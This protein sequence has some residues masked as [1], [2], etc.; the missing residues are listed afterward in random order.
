[1]N[2]IRSVGMLGVFALVAGGALANVKPAGRTD[3]PNSLTVD[4]AQQRLNRDSGYFI[5]N[6]GQWDSQALFLA[7]TPSLA[8]WLTRDGVTYDYLGNSS[9]RS[10]VAG[11]VVKMSFAG[12]KSGFVLEAEGKQSK[13]I[14]Y[15]T[16]GGERVARTT[17]FAEVWGR[18]IYAGV[19]MRSYLDNGRPRYDFVVAPGADPGQ[20]RLRFEGADSVRIE[21]GEIKLGTALGDLSHGGLF[22]YQDFG[23]EKRPVAASFRQVDATTIGFEVGAYDRTRALV[24]DPLV[25]GS[26][27]GGEGGW[28]EVRHV[29]ADPQGGVYL[30]GMTRSAAFPAV[31]GPYGFNR[32]GPM[33]AFVSKLQGD[34]YSHDYAA[35]VGGSGS[36]FGQFIRLDPFGDVWIAGRTNSANFPGNTKNTSGNTDIFVMRFRQSATNVLNPLPSTTFMFGGAGT[37]L[38]AGFDI[39]PNPNPSLNSP[40]EFV[41]AGNFVGGGIPEV[42]GSAAGQSGFIA[43]VRFQN[44]TFSVVNTATQY[45]SGGDGLQIGGVVVDHEGN[46]LLAGHV[47][48]QGNVDT[49]INPVFVTTPGVFENGR[50][51]RNNDVFIRKYSPAG[52]MIYSALIGGNGFDVIGGLAWDEA[53]AFVNA[54]SAVAVDATGN[55]YI[56]GLAGSFNFPR[57]RGVYGEVFTAFANVFVTKVSADGSQIIYSTNLRTSDRVLPS[58]IAVDQRGY[59]FVTGMVYPAGLVFP[60]TFTGMPSTAGNPNEPTSVQTWGGIQITPDALDPDWTRLEPPQ[61][62]TNEGFINV[63]NETATELVY[64]SYVGAI[65]NE[66]VFGP[67]VDRFG[68]VWI[69]GSIDSYRRYVLFNNQGDQIERAHPS[70]GRISLPDSLVSPLAFKRFNDAGMPTV[71]PGVLWG[72]LSPSAPN[73]I[74]WNFTP[75]DTNP[76]SALPTI[77]VQIARDGFL[78]KKRVGLPAVANIALIPPTV[79]GGLGASTVATFTLTS[80]APPEGADV[81]VTIGDPGIASFAPNEAQGMRLVTIPPGELTGSVTIYTRPVAQTTGVEVRATY[82]GSFKIAQLNVVPWLQQLTLIPTQIVGGNDATGRVTLAAPAPAGGITVDLITDSPSLISFRG[83]GGGAITQVT[84]PQGQ[85]SVTFTIRTEG[86]DTTRHPTITASLLGVGRTQTLTLERASLASITLTP[87]RVAG[88]TIVKGR[89]NLNGRAASAVTVNLSVPAGAPVTVPAQVVIPAGA[90]QSAEFDIHTDYVANNVT[91]PI[92]ATRPASGP[93]PAE[94]VSANLIIEAINLTSL[95]VTPAQI[96]GGGT[97]TGTVTINAPAPAGGVVINLHADPSAAVTLPATV[98]VPAGAT[99]ATFQ[100]TANV[101]AADTTVTITAARGPVTRTATLVVKGVTLTLAID[102]ASVVGGQQNSTGVVTISA[103]APAGGITVTLASSNPSGAAVPAT[104]QVPAGQTTATFPITTSAVSTTTNVTI[105]ASVGGNT[106]TAVLQ[107]RAVGVESITFR[108]AIVRGSR[109]TFATVTLDAPAPAGGAVVSLSA[110]N[111]RVVNLPAT[112]VVPAG[113]K[114]FTFTVT[115]RRVSRTL[116]TVVTAS[117]GASSASTTL[118]VTR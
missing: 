117:M 39:V 71:M 41:F 51:L 88:G 40:V 100:I 22:V 94:T 46:A 97:A 25:Y 85:T 73:Y 32:P 20:I 68:D 90:T 55:A 62:P 53:G 70:G 104:V 13:V 4:Q 36:D 107:L 78:I 10:D 91:V 16:T 86:V 19:D 7:R 33:S 79:P 101:L 65:L 43:R 60:D 44:N 52:A 102:P 75:T 58:G 80:P 105:S 18:N 30:T 72:L 69:V 63:L 89:I 31:A 87:S 34:A 109:T 93:Y 59:A 17:E 103:P 108:P 38:M 64:G 3:A 98:V 45:L 118:T 15:I 37:E 116:S 76:G 23:T 92:T 112:V 95:T 67:Y 6:A 27:Y 54:G 48:Y 82:Q 47:N 106:A 111:S 11:Q 28:D 24:I 9:Q 5:Q 110:T 66:M 14:D 81:V 61:L 77:P 1:M 26:H 42:P 50:L 96:D 57:T 49:S 83:P 56:T 74:P 113:Q 8:V 99:T 115:T 84:V 2:C 12:A 35:Y 21:G 114:T 29:V